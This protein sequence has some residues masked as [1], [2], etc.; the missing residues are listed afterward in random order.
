MDIRFLLVGD[1]PLR[2]QIEAEARS[3]GIADKIA[4]A[5]LVQPS[6]VPRYLGIMNCVVHLSYREAVSRA[7]PQALAA[8]K[9]VV[10]YAFDG[11]DEVCQ[12]GQSG[13]IVP[14]GDIESVTRFL[15]QLAADQALCDRFGRT[16]RDF[17]SK[18][19][20]VEKMIDE[21]YAWYRRVLETSPTT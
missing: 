6:D 17:V 13:F 11:A 7:L 16:G 19:F 1:G 5:G 21:Q 9:P 8:G 15:E 20:S 14:T 12:H 3:L 2:P 4:F 18:H 10:S